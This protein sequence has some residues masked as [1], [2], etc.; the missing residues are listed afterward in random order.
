MSWLLPNF[1]LEWDTSIVSNLISEEVEVGK[2]PT[3][4][5]SQKDSK[6]HSWVTFLWLVKNFTFIFRFQGV[7][8]LWQGQ[9]LVCLEKMRNAFESVTNV[10]LIYNPLVTHLRPIYDLS[11]SH[12]MNHLR[13][14]CINVWTI[15]DSSMNYL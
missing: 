5:A 2:K 6:I 13:P 11:I 14:I 4:D 12:L 3:F 15:C 8:R 9:K 10:W 7:I 1:I